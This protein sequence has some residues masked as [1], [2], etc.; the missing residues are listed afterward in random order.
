MICDGLKGLPD[1]IG[2]VLPAAK[3]RTCLIH[4]LRNSFGYASKR[5][6]PEIAANLRPVYEPPL[7]CR[8]H[9]PRAPAKGSRQTEPGLSA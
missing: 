2:S 8:L 4:V 6:W 1:S 5:H 9:L 7:Q 3:V